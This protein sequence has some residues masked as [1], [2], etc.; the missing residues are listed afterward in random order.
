MD[1]II[2]SE[3]ELK[4][5]DH[6]PPVLIEKSNSIFRTELEGVAKRTP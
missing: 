6:S 2:K 1:S 5:L 3:V 4:D